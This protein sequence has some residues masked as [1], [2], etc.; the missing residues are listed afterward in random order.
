MEMNPILRAQTMPMPQT[1]STPS[2]PGEAIAKANLSMAGAAELLKWRPRGKVVLTLQDFV[3]SDEFD[4]SPPGGE[5]MTGSTY[6]M[7]ILADLVRQDA[8]LADFLVARG[9]PTD[10]LMVGDIK[11]LSETMTAVHVI[12]AA[13]ASRA[14]S[15]A[16]LSQALGRASAS[17]TAP[18]APIAPRGPGI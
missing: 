4:L 7:A 3:R 5:P 15:A 17:H 1:A 12:E 6:G 14:K 10:S 9:T 2:A 11:N 13:V 18:A 16:T 8:W